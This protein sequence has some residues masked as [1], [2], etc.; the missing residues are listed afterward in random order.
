[1]LYWIWPY[2][3]PDARRATA[4]K[5]P[6]IAKAM[7]MMRLVSTPMSCAGV[8][9][10]GGGLHGA[11]GAAGAHEGGEGDHAD[12][13]GDEQEDVAVLDV[14]DPDAEGPPG[15]CGTACRSCVRVP[16]EDRL[17]Q[18]E[19]RPMADEGPAVVRCARAGRR[20][21]FGADGD[22]HGQRSRRRG[23]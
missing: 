16:V 22:Q 23:A 3:R 9:V 19:E 14:D 1:M 8:G 2:L 4:A 11:A 10:L 5:R 13:R 15:S 18:C 21:P 6:P 7:M 20:K 12:D 17:L